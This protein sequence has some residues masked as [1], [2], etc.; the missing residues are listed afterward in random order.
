MNLLDKYVAEVGKGLPRKNRVDIETEIRST[1]QDMLDERSAQTGKPADDAMLSELLKEYGA[2]RK[3]AASYRPAQYLIGPRLF[4]TFE[5]VTRIV[6]T[7]LLVLALIGLGTSFANHSSGPDFINALGKFVLQ[8]FG[9]LISAFGNIVLAF[10]ILE[11]VL[12][13]REL[14]V[15]E[16]KE[17][18]PA[19]LDK[20][21][22]PAEVKPAEPIFTIIFTLIGLLILNLYPGVIGLGFV[23]DGRWTFVPVLSDAF[24]HYLPWIN[25]LGILEIGLNAIL[26]REGHW[27]TFSR[28]AGLTLKIGGIILAAFMLA[29]PSLVNISAEKLANTPLASASG[30]LAPILSLVPIIVLTIVLITSTIEVGTTIYRMFNR[31]ATLFPGK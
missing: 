5:L 23:T 31:P 11:R 15:D 13:A 21:P 28:I 7:V 10:A 17:W 12:P 16:E 30:T 1:L 3:V 6:F 20:E 27:R 22:D 26:L 9:G 24:F 19:E 4:P 29:G 25:L 2:P 14:G 18:D 8:L